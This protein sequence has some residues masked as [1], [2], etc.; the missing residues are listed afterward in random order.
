M[1]RGPWPL[2][3]KKKHNLYPRFTFSMMQSGSAV[4]TKGWRFV[5]EA[6]VDRDLPVN[7]RV[8]GQLRDGK[9]PC[10]AMHCCRGAPVAVKIGL[11]VGSAKVVCPSPP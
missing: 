8:E 9:V 1:V 4:Q 3:P 7:Q 5:R 2:T 10:K 6:T 11:A